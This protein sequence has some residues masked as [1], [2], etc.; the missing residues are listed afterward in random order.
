MGVQLSGGSEAQGCQTQKWRW[1]YT[2]GYVLGSA[3]VVIQN[4]SE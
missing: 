2:T 3:R 4:G 1:V